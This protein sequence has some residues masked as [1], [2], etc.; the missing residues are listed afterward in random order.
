[1]LNEA[2]KGKPQL[3]KLAHIMQVCDKAL[4][5]DEVFNQIAKEYA[6][7]QSLWFRDFAYAWVRF[8][9]LG[10]FDLRMML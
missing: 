3:Q 2:K 5:E 8:Q 10:C 6:G 4:V 7:A 1:M 9:E